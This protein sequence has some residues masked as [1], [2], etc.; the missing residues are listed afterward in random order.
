MSTEITNTNDWR[1]LID[2]EAHNLEAAARLMRI[3]AMADDQIDAVLVL[4]DIVAAA[5]HR[6]TAHSAREQGHSA[7]SAPPPVSKLLTRFADSLREKLLAVGA[8]LPGD[9]RQR[10]IAI[11]PAVQAA[12]EAEEPNAIELVAHSIPQS[13]EAIAFAITFCIDDIERRFAS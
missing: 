7:P 9:I 11:A 1:K 5:L 6:G 13:P 4:L 3:M 12:L 10:V 2:G 8:L